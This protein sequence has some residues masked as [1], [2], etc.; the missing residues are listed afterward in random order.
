[1]SKSSS[2]YCN[3]YQTLNCFSLSMLF[4]ATLICIIC[5]F[6]FSTCI[7]SNIL[8]FYTMVLWSKKTSSETRV[9][10]NVKIK[11]IK[12]FPSQVSLE[13]ETVNKTSN[14]RRRTTF[15]VYVQHPF[16]WSNLSHVFSFFHFISPLQTIY[17]FHAKKIVLLYFLLFT[18]YQSDSDT[19][20]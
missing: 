8:F 10:W 16:C 4:T 20:Y 3:T 17:P 9:T 14:I 12:M 15:Q 13:N 6:S 19:T 5:L 11:K 1:M 2:Y 7:H 18:F